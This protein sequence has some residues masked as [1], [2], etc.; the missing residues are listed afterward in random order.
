M[1]VHLKTIRQNIW[2]GSINQS[3]RRQIRLAPGHQSGGFCFTGKY[4]DFYLYTESCFFEK[5]C[6]F[7]TLGA[8]IQNLPL[9]DY[10][11]T[12][13][14][15]GERLQDFKRWRQKCSVRLI[16]RVTSLCDFKYSDQKY[17]LCN[18]ENSKKEPRKLKNQENVQYVVVLRMPFSLRSLIS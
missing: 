18:F 1:Y 15:Q 8:K 12:Y 4:E 5:K 7:L 11:A 13:S 10:A 3:L 16:K 14:K 6:K 17:V 9:H 2:N